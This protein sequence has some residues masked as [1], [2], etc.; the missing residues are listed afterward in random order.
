[1][2]TLSTL[3]VNTGLSAN[4]GT[5]DD[6]RSAFVTTNNNIAA[7]QA[8]LDLGPQFDEA[9]IVT[10]TANTVNA[11]N[12]VANTANITTLTAGTTTVTGN[13]QVN[14]VMS[15]NISSADILAGNLTVTGVTLTYGDAIFAGNSTGIT[16]NLTVSKNVEITGNL[17]VLGNVVTVSTSEYLVEHPTIELGRIAGATL[18]SNDGNDLGLE[19]VWYDTQERKG[20]FG[21]DNSSGKFTFIPNATWAPVDGGNV[22]VFSGN[23]GT[24]LFA[25]VEANVASSGTSAFNAVTANTINVSQGIT[26]N[27]VTAIQSNI[28][29]VGT[30]SSLAVT[31]G[32]VAVTNG[33][34][35][36]SGPA[37]TTLRINGVQVSTVDAS[38]TGGPVPD[39]TT[40]QALNASTSTITGAV[41][42]SGGMGVAG[43][44]NV[45]GNLAVGNFSATNL[46]GTLTTAAQPNVT[47][48]G[49]L[50]GLTVTA[51]I[52][53]NI[54]GSA[55][56]VT[57][58]AQPAITSV[59]T[60]TGL[61]VTNTI[62]GSISTVAL[63]ADDA[64]NATNYPLFS[65]T[66][67][68]N[69]SPRTDTGFT[70]NPSTG[71]LTSTSFVGALTGSASGS[72]ATVTTAA[73]P[74]I[75][76]VGTLTGLTVIGATTLGGNINASSPTPI[77]SVGSRFGTLYA[78]A[79]NVT[80]ITTSGSFI[81]STGNV[82]IS[83][84]GKGVKFADGTFQTT[85]AGGAGAAVATANVALT[86]TT[87]ADDTT[88]AVNYPL[89][90]NIASGN[91][92]P[93]TDAGFTY[94]PF[95]G[96]LTAINFVG[97]STSAKYAD[98]AELYASDSQYEPGTVLVF[99]GTKEVT[100]TAK[101]A[102]VSVAGV[103]ST[104]PAYLMNK[105]AIDSVAVALR[106]K[107]P[108]K[109]IGEVKKGELLITS[110]TPGFAESAGLESS[111]GVAVFAKSLED[112]FILGPKVIYA[113]IL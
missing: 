37:G 96:N 113:V 28:T 85:S 110:T 17:R 88:N 5:G 63:T 108:V 42:V 8:F 10:L 56:T 72:A 1:M 62:T 18:T 54:T 80:G 21:Y 48:V 67:T 4:D 30:L 81:S 69:T 23:L 60:L 86:V 20:F 75:T 46:G 112:N 103:V 68:G 98:L 100:V 105:D 107:V 97:I 14:G 35:N 13:L 66:A 50:S 3:Q 33:N 109:V 77:G 32:N 84:T 65:N 9:N 91:T 55:A 27:L 111:M 47:S 29:S 19:F 102:D 94:N 95:S 11:G 61:T 51:T 12:L 83:T 58:A 74:A 57:A 52:T 22:E 106:G 49:T 39:P 71:A 99:G 44:L 36:I 73:Q 26:G 6:L 31:G 25:T 15:G 59:G 89:F 93:R 16:G 70:Y 90:S 40:F 104:A 41:V 79:T 87:I 64:T 7:I 34:I 78:T 38:F 82:E 2:T 53:G 45:G 43:N 24:A 101:K 92:A 76:S